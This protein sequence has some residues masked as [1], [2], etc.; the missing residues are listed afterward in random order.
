MLDTFIPF[1]MQDQ[2]RLS[3]RRLRLRHAS[4]SFGLAATKLL[5]FPPPTSQRL[6]TYLL[7]RISQIRE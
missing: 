5:A 7:C 1:G 2:V 6:T 3:I 4:A